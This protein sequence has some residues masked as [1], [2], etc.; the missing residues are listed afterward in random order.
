MEGPWNFGLEKPLRENSKLGELF[1]GSWEE[2]NVE[3]P[4]D[5]GGLGC[6]FQREV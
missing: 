2:K 4:A 1:C 5:N 6:E 3:S